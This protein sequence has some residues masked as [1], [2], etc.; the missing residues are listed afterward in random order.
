MLTAMLAAEKKLTDR[1][2]MPVVNM[3]CA[4][5]PKLMKAGGKQG[6]D[7]QLVA[8]QLGLR[9]RRD[10]HRDQARRGKEDDVDF[11]V[12]EEPEQVLPQHRIAAARGVE[13][14]PV[15][16][17]LQLEQ[18]GGEDHRREGDQDHPGEDQHR[19]GEQRHA[20]QR[21]ARRA[22]LEH[23]DED[24]DRAGNRLKSR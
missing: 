3:W 10:H 9:E 15:E 18:Q 14:R 11:G 21:H 1:V 5:T 2:G 23:A 19:P 24:L 13:E 6:E 12:A 16:R 8:D 17:A 22:G 7:D 4:Q 20:R